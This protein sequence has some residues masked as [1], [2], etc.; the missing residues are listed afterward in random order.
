MSD[1]RELILA[2]VSDLVSN[3]L[4]YDRK[5]DEELPRGSIQHAIE[6]GEISAS[7]IVKAFRR[8]LEKGCK[9]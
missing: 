9:K 7:E 5:E 3:F 4:Y 8:E 1:R 2:T 6:V